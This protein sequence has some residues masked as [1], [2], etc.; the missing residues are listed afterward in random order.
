MTHNEFASMG[1]KYS[2]KFVLLEQ[3]TST[4]CIAN[5]KIYSHGDIIFA[6]E[7]TEGKGQRGNR[8]SSLSGC[9]LMFSLVLKP[10]F[11]PASYQFML[12]MSIALG[13][14]DMLCAMKLDAKI[15]WTNDIYVDD[16]K[17]AGVLIENDV[18]G[19][20]L[21]RSVIGIGLNVNQTEFDP[22]LPN[23]VS[24]KGLTGVDYDIF[25]VFETL[26]RAILVRYNQLTIGELDELSAQYNSRL[27]R[28]DEKHTYYLPDGKPIEGVILGVKGGGKL[29][30]QHSKSLISSYLF[31]EIEFKIK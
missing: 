24:L 26:Y 19:S 6:L 27:Y 28:K 20:N 25:D 12:S 17:I 18:C 23:P 5:E 13:I 10:T 14:S 29:V 4:N 2:A 11:L 31:K 30:V 7:Q 22:S 16:S 1:E 15:K 3:T 9:N 21:S 8:W